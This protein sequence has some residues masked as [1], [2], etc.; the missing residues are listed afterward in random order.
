MLCSSQTSEAGKHFES[1]EENSPCRL[2]GV[3]DEPD[4][5]ICS[6]GRY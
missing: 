3:Q 5:H 2:A 4:L 1:G 6:F